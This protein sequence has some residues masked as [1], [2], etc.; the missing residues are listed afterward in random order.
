MSV[1]NPPDSFHISLYQEVIQKHLMARVGWLR[2][3]LQGLEEA[4]AL[5]LALSSRLV[6]HPQKVSRR[7]RVAK[8][9]TVYRYPRGDRQGPPAHRL[10]LAFDHQARLR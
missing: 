10:G 7:R 5:S 2:E 8:D 1:K 6:A 9:L 4:Y 3:V